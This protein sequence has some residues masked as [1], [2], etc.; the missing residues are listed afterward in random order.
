ME[1]PDFDKQGVLK[2]SPLI[3]GEFFEI[4]ENGLREIADAI[5][6]EQNLVKK[7]QME[8]RLNAIRL[9]SQVTAA[10]KE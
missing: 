5:H 1:K 6:R 3:R 8:K 2:E 7:E 4:E 9:L 10:Y